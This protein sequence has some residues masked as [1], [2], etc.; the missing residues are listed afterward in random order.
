MM[1]QGDQYFFEV[2]L[3]IPSGVA[4]RTA[5]ILRSKL[6]S[7]IR[8]LG[9]SFYILGPDLV[10][11]PEFEEFTGDDFDGQGRKTEPSLEG[12]WEIPGEPRAMMLSCG[13]KIRERHRFYEVWED[14]HAS[15]VSNE[16]QTIEPL[17][18]T[19][20]CTSL[21]EIFYDRNVGKALETKG[22]SGKADL[23]VKR[24]TPEVETILM[25]R[26]RILGKVATDS[27][28]VYFRLEHLLEDIQN[29]VVIPCTVEASAVMH[30]EG[31]A[32]A[33][34]SG[35]TQ[36]QGFSVN[37]RGTSRMIYSGLPRS[38]GVA[39]GTSGFLARIGFQDQ[40]ETSSMW[41]IC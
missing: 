20:A 31:F 32:A 27:L 40:E 21:S 8:M 13:K 9:E 41:W 39:R 17:L 5:G 18:F 14:G 28:H 7:A 25:S 19:H 38:Q 6:R 3:E 33:G 24:K 22:L 11:G 26:A 1:K 29:P 23:C 35:L 4:Q 16:W 34:L 30:S 12:R 37:S 2:N 15:H 10:S 36:A